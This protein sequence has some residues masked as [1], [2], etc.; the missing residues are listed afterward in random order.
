MRNPV[1]K[2]GAESP[3]WTLGSAAVTAWENVSSLSSWLVPHG[4]WPSQADRKSPAPLHDSIPAWWMSGRQPRLPATSH[5]LVAAANLS[6]TVE[7]DCENDPAEAGESIPA[8]MQDG[9]KDGDGEN[10]AVLSPGSFSA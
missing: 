10:R 5:N 6:D 8:S 2:V 3:C 9:D 4:W 7:S 1:G